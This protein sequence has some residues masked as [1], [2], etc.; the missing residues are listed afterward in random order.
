[1][2]DDDIDTLAPVEPV[3]SDVAVT[4]DEPDPDSTPFLAAPLDLVARTPTN[5]EGTRRG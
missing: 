5:E 3:A 1:M 2:T 4:I